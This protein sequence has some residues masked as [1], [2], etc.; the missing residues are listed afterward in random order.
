MLDPLELLRLPIFFGLLIGLSVLEAVFPRLPRH[1]ARQQRWSV[2]FVFGLINIGLLR[3]VLPAGLVGYALWLSEQ[4]WPISLTYFLELPFW[5]ESVICLIALDLI[6]Y[7]QHRL[8]HSAPWLWALHK[9][10]HSDRDLDTSSALR[11]H[12]GEALFSLG[13]KLLAI[14]V[15]GAAPLVVLVFE[16]LLSSFALFNHA[17]WRLGGFDRVLRFILVTPDMHRLHHRATDYAESGNYGFCLS[18]WDRLFTSYRDASQAPDMTS[19]TLGL[20][21]DRP[22]DESIKGLMQLPFLR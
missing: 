12:P 16:V 14:T 15:L 6:I 8:L 10:H 13:V 7:G 1:L 11:F 2:N 3:V 18:L 9:M 21:D 19:I 22:H 4:G 5:V 20:T 17:N